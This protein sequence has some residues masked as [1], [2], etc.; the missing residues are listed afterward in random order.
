MSHSNLAN[1]NGNNLLKPAP[2]ALRVVI[3]SSVNYLNVKSLTDGFGST[4][5]TS[6]SSVLISLF[7]FWVTRIDFISSFFFFVQFNF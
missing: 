6:F 1:G 4:H 7:F 3:R 5:G 2:I